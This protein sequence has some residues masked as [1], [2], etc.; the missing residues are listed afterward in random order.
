M[1]E[2]AVRAENLS[3][4]YRLG[5]R[6]RYY[7]LRDSLAHFFAA[8][9]RR[10]RNGRQLSTA[11]SDSPSAVAS[12]TASRELRSEFIWALKDV[13]FDIKRG[14]VVGI[15]G[16]N[17]AGK[18]TLLKILSQ[19]TEPTEGEARVYGRVGSLLEV[20]TGFHPELTGRENIYLNGA[21]LGMKKSEIESEFDEIVSFA[22]VDKFLDTPIKRYS[23][24]MYMRLAFAVAAHL[25][26]EILLVDEVL[27]V[28][29]SAFQKKCLGKMG[30]VA[31]AGRTVLLV[32]HSVAAINRLCRRVLW[33]DTGKIQGIGDTESVVSAYLSAC[34]GEGSER[35]W[36]EPGQAPGNEKIRLHA[37]RIRT[38]TGHA[39]NTLATE[40]GFF[41]EVAYD[42]RDDLPPMRIVIEVTTLD[43]TTV[44]LTRDNY[45]NRWGT[46]VRRPGRY[47]SR[48]HIPGE[49]LNAGSYTLTV[50][51]EIPFVT[52]LFRE[53]DVLRLVIER[54]G[55]VGGEYAESWPGIICPPLQLD[56]MS[57]NEH[58]G[59]TDSVMIY[60][61][62]RPEVR[63][64]SGQ[65]ETAGEKLR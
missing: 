10:L 58:F 8:P 62:A 46:E 26:P 18:S 53:E 60:P 25:H 15:I 50:S 14:E 64:E 2:I 61:R 22:E 24:G 54:T 28:G 21:I 39:A 49:L 17:G 43:G 31:Q 42:I 56:V 59:T 41:I 55:G 20:G 7:T 52:F 47:T 33:L 5:E 12:Q 38:E 6:Q 3:K 32:S 36:N 30:E 51:A 23:S 48:C 4:R 16:R 19:I 27:A 45:Q 40:A 29:D 63:P 34:I 35:V 11:G 13:S 44:F 37:V 9:L 57:V 1:S 65:P